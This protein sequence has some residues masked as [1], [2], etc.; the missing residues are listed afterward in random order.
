MRKE[1][2]TNPL[3]NG[4]RYSETCGAVNG[5]KRMKFIRSEHEEKNKTILRVMGTCVN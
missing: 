4:S 1:K 2:K 5:V 3:M